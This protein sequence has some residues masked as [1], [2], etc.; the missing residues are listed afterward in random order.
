MMVKY[1]NYHLSAPRNNWWELYLD[2]L[3]KPLFVGKTVKTGA[4]TFFS[5]GRK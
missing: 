1:F 3:E 2:L 5:S 4:V